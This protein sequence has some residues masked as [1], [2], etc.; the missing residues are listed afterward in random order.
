MARSDRYRGNAPTMTAIHVNAH[1]LA[2]TPHI[3]QA[4][5][6]VPIVELKC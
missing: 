3:C 1:A 6:I 4:A 2:R 5:Q